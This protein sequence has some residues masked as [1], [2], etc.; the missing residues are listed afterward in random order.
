[1]ASSMGAIMGT[2]TSAGSTCRALAARAVGPPQG[3]RFITPLES[4]IRQV[5][6]SGFM[7]RRRYSGNMA[8]TQIM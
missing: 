4:S 1:M 5:M 6:I 8:A 7:P 3:V 2:K